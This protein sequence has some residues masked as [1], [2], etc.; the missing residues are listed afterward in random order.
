MT[1]KQYRAWATGVTVVSILTLI[2]LVFFAPRANVGYEAP[3]AATVKIKGAGTGTGVLIRRI[4]IDTRQPR[5]FAWTAKH[6]VVGVNEVSA[7][8]VYHGS[9]GKYTQV[10]SPGTV[11]YRSECDAALVSVEG[12]LEL[13]GYAEFDLTDNPIGTPIFHVGNL[14]GDF[15]TSL[16]QGIISQRNLNRSVAP[17]WPW[18]LTDQSDLVICPGS[19]GGPVFS[20]RGIIGLVVGGPEQGKLGIACYVPVRLLLAETTKDHMDWSI[21]GKYCPSD[22]TVAGLAARE[23]VTLDSARP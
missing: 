2:A 19:S 5:L 13:Y 10:I 7:I 22:K 3:R 9:N 12:S 16:T 18:D 11:I 14:L 8:R 21:V 15:D 20:S 6:A 1:F 23:R 4:T 17:G